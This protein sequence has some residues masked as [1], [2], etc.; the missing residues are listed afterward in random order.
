MI[1]LFVLFTPFILLAIFLLFVFVGCAALSGLSDYEIAGFKL[2]FRYEQ[3][4]HVD[5]QSISWMYEKNLVLDGDGEIGGPPVPGG[6]CD[7][8]FEVSQLDPNLPLL[9][10]NGGEH[11]CGD[12][13]GSGVV[14]CICEI[15]LTPPPGQAA[16]DPIVKEITKPTSMLTGSGLLFELKRIGVGPNFKLE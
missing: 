2:K 7:G 5:V 1:D 11:E 10:P 12:L 14:N 15:T 3:D 9:D 8:W 13:E 4:L 16:A 6:P